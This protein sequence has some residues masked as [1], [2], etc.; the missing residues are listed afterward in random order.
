MRIQIVNGT[1]HDLKLEVFDIDDKHCGHYERGHQ[2]ESH[3]EFVH[4]DYCHLYD[5]NV[6]KCHKHHHDNIHLDYFQERRHHDGHHHHNAYRRREYCEIHGYHL[7]NCRHSHE[8]RVYCEIHKCYIDECG[9]RHKQ[10]YCE[11]HKCR[12]DECKHHHHYEEHC[13]PCRRV[14]RVRSHKDKTFEIEFGN[15]IYVKNCDGK[16]CA[17]FGFNEQGHLFYQ[18]CDGIKCEIIK[19]HKH[20]QITFN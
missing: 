16:I 20:I 18:K 14:K 12:V 7:D 9:H 3:H 17:T 5:C 19:N 10:V 13:D 6:E 11:I 8:L 1:R 2:R 15:V 4:R